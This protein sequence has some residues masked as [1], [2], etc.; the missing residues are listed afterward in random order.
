MSIYSL[1]VPVLASTLNN[2]ATDQYKTQI[3]YSRRE[4]TRIGM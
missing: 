2:I 1:F 3:A 4:P